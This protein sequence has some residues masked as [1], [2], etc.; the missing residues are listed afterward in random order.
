MK[1]E[2]VPALK[3]RCAEEFVRQIEKP[4]SGETVRIFKEA[5]QVSR[6]LKRIK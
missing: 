3:G 6:R 4:P 2:P 1:P 5:E